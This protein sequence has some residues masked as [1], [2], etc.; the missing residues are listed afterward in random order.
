MSSQ[1]RVL[2]ETLSFELVTAVEVWAWQAE[3]LSCCAY[4]LTRKKAP[5]FF[6]LRDWKMHFV[7]SALGHRTV[8]FS[9][10]IVKQVLFRHAAVGRLRSNGEWRA[11]ISC[12]NLPF[13][14]YNSF[15]I[16]ISW[17]NDKSRNHVDVY[18]LHVA[19]MISQGRTGVVCRSRYA[20]IYYV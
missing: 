16:Y 18:M 4:Y 15:L 12:K 17:I 1:R 6:Y 5:F 11:E 19:E 9:L 8:W 20:L 7:C 14:A 2:A 3:H 10:I 13:I